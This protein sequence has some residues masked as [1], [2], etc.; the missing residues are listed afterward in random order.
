MYFFLRY[1]NFS[2]LQTKIKTTVLTTEKIQLAI[3]LK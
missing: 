1:K 2:A 3:V